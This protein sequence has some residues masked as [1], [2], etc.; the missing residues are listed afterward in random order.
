MKLSVPPT[1]LTLS[2]S[3]IEACVEEI[4]IFVA[5]NPPA[6]SV[7]PPIV[8]VVDVMSPLI[9]AFVAVNAPAVV[10]LNGALPNVACPN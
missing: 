6:A 7:N 1:I 3:D 5:V 10:T 8:P 2:P 9:V 4:L